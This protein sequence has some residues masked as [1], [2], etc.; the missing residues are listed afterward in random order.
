M[1]RVWRSGG[2]AAV[3][4]VATV[5]AA[6][7]FLFVAVAAAD[8]LSEFI[9]HVFLSRFCLTYATEPRTDTEN[10]A[11]HKWQTTSNGCLDL[12]FTYSTSRALI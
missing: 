3:T 10:A 11:V 6:L 4:A 12:P 7:L 1:Q 5:A 2:V 9:D 8:A